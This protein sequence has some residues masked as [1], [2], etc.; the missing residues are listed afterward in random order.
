MG[1]MLRRRG[2][3]ALLALAAV[4]L[5]VCDLWGDVLPDWIVSDIEEED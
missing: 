4:A 5:L 3:P 2:L 1:P